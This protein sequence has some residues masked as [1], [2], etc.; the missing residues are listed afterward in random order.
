MPLPVSTVLLLLFPAA[1][2]YFFGRDIAT[3]VV[4]LLGRDH[5]STVVDRNLA[6]VKSG[7]LTEVTY[8]YEEAGRHYTNHTSFDPDAWSCYRPGV[9]L[10]IRSIRVAGRGLSV[11]H[12]GDFRWAFACAGGI[13]WNLVFVWVTLTMCLAALRQR[14]VLA[15]GA[16]VIG[17]VTTKTIKKG[18]HT[19]YH[20][21]V[22]YHVPNGNQRCAV[23]AVERREYE[24]ANIGDEVVVFYD[25][26]DPER[27]VIY[28]Y[29]PYAVRGMEMV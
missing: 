10:P 11:A 28:N 1:G 26:T 3:P 5:T 13:L 20:L 22:A 23:T 8:E 21:S 6:K 12:T 15:T 9:T 25:C 19:S 4:L 14:N 27:S 29:S 17:S 2:I 7:Y 16:V 24:S 18:K